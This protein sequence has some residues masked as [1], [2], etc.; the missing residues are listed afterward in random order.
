MDRCLGSAHAKYNVEVINQKGGH[1]RRVCGSGDKACEFVRA[2][3][4]WRS[5]NAM[6]ISVLENEGNGFKVADALLVKAWVKVVVGVGAIQ[7]AMPQL[8]DVL[9]DDLMQLLTSGEFADMTLQC[10][11]ESI[12]CHTLIL[13]ARSP[14]FK[15]MFQVDMARFG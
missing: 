14:V 11:E 15:R 1:A 9:T 2:G 3:V 10:G 7:K 8:D 6:E 13:M 5:P 4:E 12:S